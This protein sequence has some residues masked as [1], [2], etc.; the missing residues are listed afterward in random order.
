MAISLRR[1]EIAVGNTAHRVTAEAICSA[2]D[3]LGFHVFCDGCVTLYDET[4]SEIG[5]FALP[6]D[7]A[8]R[9]AVSIGKRLLFSQGKRAYCVHLDGAGPID[10][11]PCEDTHNGA[12]FAV[13]KNGRHA[14]WPCS[15]DRLI[16]VDTSTWELKTPTAFNNLDS[17]NALAAFQRGLITLHGGRDLLL[18]GVTANG[19]YLK[20]QCILHSTAHDVAA[21]DKYIILARADGS[22][23]V[24]QFL[25]DRLVQ[26]YFNLCHSPGHSA[27]GLLASGEL[28]SVGP[29]GALITHIS[30]PETRLLRESSAS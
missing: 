7:G 5:S 3:G 10:L 16:A 23:I 25:H 27:V 17:I 24:K 6:N 28:F 4:F 29:E 13:L 30:A 26:C 15:E 8:V 2:A 12:S 22:V 1:G 19:L 21:N 11:G 18:W 20:L 9:S 14:A